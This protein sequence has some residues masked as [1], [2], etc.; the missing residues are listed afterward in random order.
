MQKSSCVRWCSTSFTHKQV[1]EIY[2]RSAYWS[3][4]VKMVQWWSDYP[5]SLLGEAEIVRNEWAKVQQ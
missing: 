4:R 3:E 5:G 1:R 2:N